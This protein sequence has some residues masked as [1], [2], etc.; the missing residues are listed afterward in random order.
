VEQ[1]LAER[2]QHLAF[3]PPRY[4]IGGTVGGMVAAGLSGPSRAASG[5]VRDHVLG[6][7]LLN[8]R[9]EVLRFGGQVMKNVAGYDVSRLLAGSLGT[10]GVI[11]EVSLRTV[12]RPVEVRTLHFEMSESKALQQVNSWGGLP[13]PITASAW[14]DGGLWVRLA[15][16]HAAVASGASTLGGDVVAPAHA[17]WDA[18]RD[19]RHAWFEAA[20]LA[21]NAG[22]CLWRLSVPSTSPP[23]GLPGACLAEW[24]GAQRWV[25]GDS[26]AAA[27]VQACA[28]AARGHATR[29]RGAGDGRNVFAPLSAPVARIHQRLMEAFDPQRIFN[30]GRLH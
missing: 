5:A 12:P 15:G 23:L 8:G 26:T 10:L 14:M 29:F 6:A 18:L 28:H 20:T 16:A 24:G 11:V 30:R 17:P 3:E 21:V 13:L 1:A 19:H 27:A 4:A 9:G 2:G 7:L 25:L 22:A